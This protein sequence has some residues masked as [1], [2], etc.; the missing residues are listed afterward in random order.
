MKRI[1]F[2]TNPRSGTGRG[3]PVLDQVR[4]LLSDA[5]IE[6]VT[7]ETSGSGAEG[8]NLSTMDLS[9]LDAVCAVGGDGTFHNVLNAMLSREDGRVLP[10]GLLPGGTGNA[11]AH[12]LSATDPMRAAQRIAAFEPKPMD[13]MGV[14]SQGFHGYAFNLAGFG[15]MER[16]NRNAERWR[17][18]K[19]RRYDAAA[20]WEILVHRPYSATLT[21][22][23][24]DPVEGTFSLVAGLNT[25]HTGLGMRAAPHAELADGKLDLV[26]VRRGRRRELV[27]MMRN[28]YTGG[29]IED[30]CCEYLQATSFSIDTRTPSPLNID[31]ETRGS[32]PVTVTLLPG[33]VHLL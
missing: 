23:R 11:L 30:P 15:M 16:A 8:T 32:T 22:D 20:L 7:W 4:P 3:G 24:G 27:G 9:G 28:I 31:G 1:A 33:R 6:V 29:H 26:V 10:L 2:I 19:G 5:G 18:L 14:R 25:V 17:W 13:L 21:I 12:D